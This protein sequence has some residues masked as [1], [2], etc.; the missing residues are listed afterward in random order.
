MGSGW[1]KGIKGVAGATPR[2]NRG[3]NLGISNET[4][5]DTDPVICPEVKATRRVPRT[6]CDIRQRTEV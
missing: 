4:L 1:G 6:P 5:A 2:S 3:R